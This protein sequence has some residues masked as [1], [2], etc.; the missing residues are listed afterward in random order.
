MCREGYSDFTARAMVG[1]R[2]LDDN[3]QGLGLT[4]FRGSAPKDQGSG[5]M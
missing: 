2:D 5:L 1:Y 4:G 3:V